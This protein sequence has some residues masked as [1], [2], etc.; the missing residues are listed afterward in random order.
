MNLEVVLSHVAAREDQA[1]PYQFP[2]EVE[3]LFR[4][5]MASGR[6]ST[7]DELLREALYAL[8]EQE[9]DLAA[10]REAVAE[11][12]AGDPGVSLNEAFDDVRRQDVSDSKP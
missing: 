11:L 5:R 7:E 8:A 4:E 9:D 6:Y 12:E 10:V 3:Q 2:P 1:M